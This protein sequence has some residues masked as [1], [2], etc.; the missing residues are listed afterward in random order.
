ML[1]VFA[2]FE[3]AMIRDRVNAGLSCAEANGKRL[4]RPALSADNRG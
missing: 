2:E 4:G 1:A 3:R